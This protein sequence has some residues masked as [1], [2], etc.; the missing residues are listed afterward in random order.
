MPVLSMFY[1]IIVR[2]YRENNAKHK[3]P[4]LHA[5]YNGEFVVVDFNGI[6]LDGVLPP[7]KMRMLLT[8][9]DIHQEE[10]IANWSLLISDGEFFKID[11]L[12]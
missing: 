2:M 10:L 9:I 3:V 12:K 7:K 8:W 11:P 6:I 4:H 5:E 1:G